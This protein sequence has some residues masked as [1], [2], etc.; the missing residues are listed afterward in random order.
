[1]P[2]CCVCHMELDNYD[3]INLCNTII[4]YLEYVINKRKNEEIHHPNKRRK[5]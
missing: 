3:G 5:L 2:N 1:M 4:C